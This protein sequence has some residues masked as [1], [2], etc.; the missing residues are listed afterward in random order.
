[1]AETKKAQG[2]LI[3]INPADIAA[4]VSNPR[5]INKNMTSFAELVQSIQGTGVRVPVQVREKKSGKG[6][7]LLA[8]SRRLLACQHLKLEA[9]PAI[10]YGKLPDDEAFEIT[11]T[12]NFAREDLTPLEQGKAVSILLTKYKGDT[13]AVASK[14]GKST[15]WVARRRALGENLS[16]RWKKGIGDNE[17]L[18]DL[19]AGHLQLI[20]AFP[21]TVQDDV[22]FDE[23][24]RNCWGGIPTVTELENDLATLLQLL[25][26]APWLQVDPKMEA[27]DLVN[28]LWDDTTD[29]VKIKKQDRCLDQ[30]CFTGKMNAWLK[31]GFADAI[32]SFPNLKQI[33]PPDLGNHQK[34]NLRIEFGDTCCAWQ[35]STQKAPGAHPG[36]LLAGPDAG[37]VE[38]FKPVAVSGRGSGKSKTPGTPTPLK[39]RRQLLEKKRA[40]AL[41]PAIINQVQQKAVADIVAKN[42]AEVVMTLA[43]LFG[44]SK[45]FDGSRTW[46]FSGGVKAWQRFRKLFGTFS[47]GVKAWQR[48]R[49]LSAGKPLEV[50]ERL[51]CS[52]REVLCTSLIYNGP[53]T[54]VEQDRVNFGLS[55]AKLLALDV[56][57]LQKK[58]KEQIP[59][60]K[61]WARLNENGTPK[62]TDKKSKPPID[63]LSIIRARALVKQ[64]PTVKQRDKKMKGPSKPKA[65]KKVKT[66][67]AKAARK[68]R[69]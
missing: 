47:G 66:K 25:S 59:E 61:S 28:G 42:K 53:V 46:T 6:Y 7:E 23:I 54:Q 68:G 14:L 33:A 38:W 32:K 40:S 52:V 31:R 30:T 44:V 58:I 41:L 18:G 4:N 65:T 67:K 63:N 57:A 1:M 43:Y 35:K 55:I 17:Y 26:Q 9:I 8:G 13:K 20:A 10:N 45:P 2:Q 34:E 29:A 3:Q 69:R 19:T 51:W 11:F 39:E 15:K 48:F 64:R 56:K 21:K 36:F 49:K 37:K 16:D 22:L 24:E 60:P 50:L 27:H 62:Q 5:A 12:E